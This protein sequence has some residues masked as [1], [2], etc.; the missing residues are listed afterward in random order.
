[1][2]FGINSVAL[3]HL[4]TIAVTLF[5]GFLVGALA[6]L[7]LTHREIKALEKEVDHF[8]D[9]YFEEIDRWRNKYVND[10]YEAY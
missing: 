3:L 2:E 9:L 1:M 7:F 5:V 4:T 6:T 8:R 10:D